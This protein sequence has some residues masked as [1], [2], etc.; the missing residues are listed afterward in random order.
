[1]IKDVETIRLTRKQINEVVYKINDISITLAGAI[2]LYLQGNYDKYDVFG[3]SEILFKLNHCLDMCE[4]LLGDRFDK[5]HK[6]SSRPKKRYGRN[7]VVRSLELH[8]YTLHNLALSFLD[9][10]PDRQGKFYTLIDDWEKLWFL[11]SSLFTL[12]Y[13]GDFA[14]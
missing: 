13:V 4:K 8:Q 11:Y 9:T 10:E 6:S 14:R 3:D 5:L 12:I 2:Q 7:K 1:M